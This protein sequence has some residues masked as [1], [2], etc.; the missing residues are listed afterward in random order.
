[1]YTGL[2]RLD[3]RLFPVVV[4][5]LADV[6]GCVGASCRASWVRVLRAELLTRCGVGVLVC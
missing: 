2:S 3:G 6:G 5:K 1:M 4:V